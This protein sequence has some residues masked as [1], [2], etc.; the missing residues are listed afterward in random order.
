MVLNTYK[1]GKRKRSGFVTITVMSIKE[2][3]WRDDSLKGDK[4][5]LLQPQELSRTICSRTGATIH[6]WGNV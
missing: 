6:V 5:V 3:S 1:P 2:V 4:A